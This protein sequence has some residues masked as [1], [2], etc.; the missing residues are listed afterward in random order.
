M[1]S[2]QFTPHIPLWH[3]EGQLMQFFILLFLSRYYVQKFS[4][5]S[6]S[7]APVVYIL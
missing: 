1:S 6:S 3:A 2:L 5:T 4:E 7:L